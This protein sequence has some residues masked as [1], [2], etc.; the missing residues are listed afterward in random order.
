MFMATI[1]HI[2]MESILLQRPSS[3]Y[4]SEEDE[5]T[6]FLGHASQGHTRRQQLKSNTRDILFDHAPPPVWRRAFYSLGGALA[7]AGICVAVAVGY[8]R[9]VSTTSVDL[10]AQASPMPILTVPKQTKC[11][12]VSVHQD[13]T[14][15]VVGNVCGADAGTTCPPKG[16]VASADCVPGIASYVNETACSVCIQGHTH[17]NAKDNDQATDRHNHSNPLDASANNYRPRAKYN[18]SLYDDYANAYNNLNNPSSNYNTGSY[19][20][21]CSNNKNA[22]TN[23]ENA[24]SNNNNA[25]SN[26]DVSFNNNPSSN[27]NNTSSNNKNVSPNNASSNNNVSSNSNNTAN[28]NNVS[29]NNNNVSS[30]NNNA[31]SSNNNA[32]PSY[33]FDTSKCDNGNSAYNNVSSI[34]NI[35]CCSTYAGTRHDDHTYFNGTSTRRSINDTSNNDASSNNGNVNLDPNNSNSNSDCDEWVYCWNDNFANENTLISTVYFGHTPVSNKAAS[36]TTI[37]PTGKSTAPPLQILSTTEAPNSDTSAAN[38]DAQ[39]ATDAPQW[40]TSTPALET[41]SG[42][43]ISPSTTTTQHQSTFTAAAKSTTAP[44]TTPLITTNPTTSDPKLGLLTITLPMPTQQTTP[45]PSPTTTTTEFQHPETPPTTSPSSSLTTNPPPTTVAPSTTVPSATTASTSSTVAPIPTSASSTASPTTVAPVTTAPETASPAST[46]ASTTATPAATSTTTVGPATASPSNGAS[47]NPATTAATVA[48][49]TTVPSATTASTSSTVAPIPTSASST[50]SPT[51]VAPVTTAPET[52]SPASITASSTSAIQ[53]ESPTVSVMTPVTTQDPKISLSD[54]GGPI[55]G[56]FTF[57]PRP[58]LAPK[59][60]TVVATSAGTTTSSEATASPTT[61]TLGTNSPSVTMSNPP[62]PTNANT[63]LP[64]TT[65]SSSNCVFLDHDPSGI[66]TAMD[67]DKSCSVNLTELLDFFRAAKASKE[68]SLLDSQQSAIEAVVSKYTH[69]MECA[70][71]VYDTMLVDHEIHSHDQL[72][73]VLQW[74]QTLCV[75]SPTDQVFTRDEAVA[76]VQGLPSNSTSFVV[77]AVQTLN[78][79]PASQSLT[80][81]ELDIL[82]QSIESGACQEPSSPFDVSMDAI[83]AQVRQVLDLVNTTTT[84]AAGNAIIETQLQNVLGQLKS[85]DA[86]R[87]NVT[88]LFMR[89]ESCVNISVLVFGRNHVISADDLAAA[90]RWRRAICMVNDDEAAFRLVDVNNDHVISESEIDHIVALARDTQ[91]PTLANVSTPADLFQA[92]L[93]AIRE[94]Y[95][96]TL[97]CSHQAISEL[98]NPLDRT[99]TETQFKGY[100]IWMHSHCDAVQPDLS[101]HGLPTKA[102][103][104][105]NW[106]LTFVYAAMTQSKIADV[107]LLL[108]SNA[109]NASLHTLFLDDHYEL[110]ETCFSTAFRAATDGDYDVVV[111]ATKQCM[112]GHIPLTMPVDIL[113]S[114]PAFR[115]LLRTHFSPELSDLD[116]AIAKAAARADALV[117]RKEKLEQCIAA[118]VDDAAQGQTYIK[119][120]KLAPAQKMAAECISI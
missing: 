24:S 25:S 92:Q 32:S 117:A 86:I 60:P 119:Q 21:T 20:N 102:A 12:P 95:D 106:S 114:K 53:T 43:T 100:D 78:K 99:M 59:T 75:Q 42:T 10:A 71:R 34:N 73:R 5:S 72:Q 41:A 104:A 87:T 81:A 68:Q 13:A 56:P 80:K 115:D 23:N 61:S 76:Y 47:T 62:T 57:G 85:N 2:S 22:S 90:D 94:T 107:R 64:A 65:G 69:A 48:P 50:A 108:A 31:G 105:A 19:Y 70:K 111:D 14:Y 52:A 89:V 98:G 91:L 66:L 16:A 93:F 101:L 116:A 83:F 1:S 82:V 54:F 120:T 27:N 67:T 40:G 33:N 88:T 51:T 45:T 77:C 39:I 15:C 118:A 74:L 49:S 29:P 97:D 110:L 79:L 18:A 6:Q 28:D 36:T 63:A 35:S 112:Q 103:L 3:S 4:G 84:A 7:V 26:N 8:Q 17:N 46:T 30:N 96:R 37:S 44:Q 109:T 38:G 11:T 58:T 9:H 113:L 55:I